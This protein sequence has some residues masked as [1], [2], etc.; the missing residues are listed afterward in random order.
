MVEK[1]DVVKSETKTR[2]P[3]GCRVDI[4]LHKSGVPG[5]ASVNCVLAGGEL[6]VWHVNDPVAP[7]RIWHIGTWRELA[8]TSSA[9]CNRAD[10]LC[11]GPA[12]EQFREDDAADHCYPLL[13]PRRR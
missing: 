3:P 11:G 4:G 2:A 6:G 7:W 13:P 9:P 1:G 5:Q 12:R 10:R 8:H